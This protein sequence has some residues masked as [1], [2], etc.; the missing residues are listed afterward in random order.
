MFPEKK[1]YAIEGERKASDFHID[2]ESRLII[3]KVSITRFNWID[4]VIRRDFKS[5]RMD[6]R[7]IA[8]ENRKQLQK[9]IRDFKKCYYQ[10][11][12]ENISN[13]WE[14]A[15]LIVGRQPFPMFPFM[16]E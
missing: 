15:C 5:I 8:G 10:L 12:G 4:S 3:G 14:I 6:R 7:R 1:C 11:D 13:I 16:R 2:Y 9:K